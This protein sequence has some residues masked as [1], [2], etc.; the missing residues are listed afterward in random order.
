M[1][2]VGQSFGKPIIEESAGAGSS[3]KGPESAKSKTDKISEK[4]KDLE[5][6]P[7]KEVVNILK[8]QEKDD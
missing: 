2:T 5:E 3:T 1:K 7:K 6:T 8:A 4:A